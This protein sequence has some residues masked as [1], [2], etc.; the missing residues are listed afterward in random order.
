MNRISSWL[1]RSSIPAFSAYAMIAS[2]ST[3]ACMYAFRKPFTVATFEG[4]SWGGI[5]YKILLIT[6]QVVGYMLSKFIGIKVVSE[7]P[8]RR[9][10]AGILVLVV[11]AGLALLG[12]ALV[13]PPYNVF[14]LFLNG[15]PLGMVWGLVFGYLEGRRTT[16]LLGAG[17]SVSFIVASGGVKTVGKWLLLSGISPF[18]MPLLTGLLFALPL[19]VSVYLLHQLPPPSAEDE[20]L[21]T[22]RSPMNRSQRYRLLRTF[23]P[24]LIL[25]I[26]AYVLLTAF[27]DFRDNFMA[28]L[29]QAFGYG[30]NAMLCSP[31]RKCRWRWR[32]WW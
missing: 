14:F 15:L 20:R 9:R 18:W 12:F 6:T 26:L 7:L 5:D 24:G 27:R 8:P 32:S 22:R 17:L 11:L 2:F 25:L 19:V 13:S 23:A 30:D 31:Q 28:E 1:Q 16:E 4:L 10:A 29:W 21:R 3:Y